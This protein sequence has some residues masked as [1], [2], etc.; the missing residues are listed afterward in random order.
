MSSGRAPQEQWEAAV[1]GVL[2]R[3]L[4]GFAKLGATVVGVDRTE[5]ACD[6]LRDKYRDNPNVHIVRADLYRRPSG[7][8]RCAI[9]SNARRVSPV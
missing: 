4:T 9:V 1:D 2:T 6:F 5:A 3:W 7:V 8:V